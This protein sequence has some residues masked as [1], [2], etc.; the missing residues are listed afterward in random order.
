MGS[1]P[2]PQQ[3]SQPEVDPN[4]VPGGGEGRVP[5][6]D[7]AGT[8]HLWEGVWPANLPPGHPTL[9]EELAARAAAASPAR[10]SELEGY[11]VQKGA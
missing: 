5:G 10:R 7:R 8:H 3:P 4:R 9:N 11:M 2:S 1:A 6:V